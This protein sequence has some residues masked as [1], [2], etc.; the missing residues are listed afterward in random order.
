MAR[1]LHLLLS[2][3]AAEATHCVKA[4]KIMAKNLVYR[5]NTLMVVRNE[6][7]IFT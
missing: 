3:H 1:M 2:S 6:S 7:Q 4:H 5:V